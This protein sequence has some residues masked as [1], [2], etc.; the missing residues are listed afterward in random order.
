MWYRS[1][2]TILNT[3]KSI[4]SETIKEIITTL[5]CQENANQNYL[6]IQ[7]YSCQNAQDWYQKW[8]LMLV[9]IWKKRST[10]HCWWK[11]K[12]LQTL[13]NTVW[14]FIKKLGINLP[15]DLAL[16]VLAVYSKDA[17]SNHKDTCPTML[18]PLWL[19]TT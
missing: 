15:Q 19:E 18:I 9:R 16:S 11:W 3:E 17:V 10:T 6:E 13:W 14:Q 4:G 5:S 7:F 2:Q 12:L 1:K 8:Q